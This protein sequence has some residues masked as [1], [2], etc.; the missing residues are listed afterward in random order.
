LHYL[1][2]Q[3]EGIAF[4]LARQN[5]L[6]ADEM[7]TGKTIQALGLVN[8]DPAIRRVLVICPATLK[9]NWAYEARR[10]L[11]RPFDVVIVDGPVPPDGNLLA[12]T[13]Y[14]QVRDPMRLSML[15][16][17]WDLLIVDESHRL[18][19][20]DA[21]QTRAICGVP[22]R[23]R[24]N[25]YG[26]WYTAS[27]GQR[28]LVHAASRRI[29]LTGTP[30]LN[31]PAELYTTLQ[32]L[33]PGR[34]RSR[35]QFE[36]R[37]CAG[38][39]ETIWTKGRVQRSIWRA[40]GASNI[41]ELASILRETIMIRRL[42]RDV[43]SQLPPKR[44]SLV[45]LSPPDSVDLSC[46]RVLWEKHGLCLRTLHVSLFKASRCPSQEAV[47]AAPDDTT[48]YAQAVARLREARRIA[49]TE[50][51]RVRHTTALAKAPVVAEWVA[52]I[53][54]SERKVVVFAHHQDVI[55]ILAER[56]RD[57]GAVVLTGETPQKER[58][59]LVERFQT[60]A[61]TRV[62]IGSI[63]AAGVGLTLTAARVA[64]F[65][66]LDWVP[67]NITQAEDR[68][69]RLGQTD[70]VNVYH[71]VIDG[72]IDQRLASLL[73]AK[74]E[75]SDRLLDGAGASAEDMVEELLLGLSSSENMR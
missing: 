3:E 52:D 50:I 56:L 74:Q 53:L 11:V 24:K 65:A 75:L 38:H 54:D 62:F 30:V 46:E 26:R 72:T 8:A 25:A 68:I 60:A 37:Y 10:W 34:W 7:G 22:P 28:G 59:G 23:Y 48:A 71:L 4:C 39:T 35:H 45:I 29:F 20:P 67:A 70:P 31:R 61:G 6:I 18:K 40:D 73:I 16:Q 14:E 12:I 32:A 9:T 69:H 63:T 1:P 66:E 21:Q 44:R 36:V 51:S 41:E 47:Q 42:K 43:L 49:L 2:F 19:N 13:N 64:V 5:A 17:H 58:D 57:Y 33:D 15:M 55:A 27:A